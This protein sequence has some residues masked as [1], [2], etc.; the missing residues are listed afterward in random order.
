MD[1]SFVCFLYKSFICFLCYGKT[2][3]R[4]TRVETHSP[5]GGYCLNPLGDDIVSLVSVVSSLWNPEKIC[6][7]Y[8]KVV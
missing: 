5:L 1:S 7:N 2:D 6:V 3:C 8:K 4:G